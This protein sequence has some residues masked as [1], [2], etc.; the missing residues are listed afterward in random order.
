MNIVLLG[1]KKE[2]HII[3]SDVTSLRKKRLTSEYI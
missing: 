2:S 3:D 1:A